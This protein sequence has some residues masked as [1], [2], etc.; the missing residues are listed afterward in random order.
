MVLMLYFTHMKRAGFTIVEL[1]IVIVVIA[2]LAAITIVAYN[3]IQQNAMTSLLKSDISNA[4]KQM[5]LARADT[6]S[7]PT[8]FPAALKTSSNVSL[9]LSQASS[10]FCINGEHKQ[11]TSIRW[12]YE[13]TGG[14]QQGLCSGAVIAGSETGMNPNLI[15][16]TAFGTGSGWSLNFQTIAG[17][18]LTT[19]SGASDDPFPSRPVLVLTNSASTTTSWCVLQSSGI[20]HSAVQAGKTYTRSFWV[21]KIGAHSGAINLFGILTPGGANA[22]FNT[23]GT[24]VPSDNWQYVS[25]AIAATSNSDSSKVLYHPLNCNAFTTSG[26]SLEFQGYE[27]REQ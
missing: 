14:L 5:E 21:R 20:N 10:G 9:S 7:Y 16:N 4:A 23:S 18:S 19:R 15:T 13:S 17:R 1:L 6:D 12:R 2:I 22:S 3:G 26:W 8:S 27:L 25:A 24:V 11:N